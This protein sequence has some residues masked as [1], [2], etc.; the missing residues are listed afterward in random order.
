MSGS[1]FMEYKIN[2][3][4]KYF[5]PNTVLFSNENERITVAMLKD[6]LDYILGIIAIESPLVEPY[7]TA[8]TVFSAMKMIL[9]NKKSSKPSKMDM[10]TTVDVL[11]EITNLF[12]KSEWEKEQN[13]RYAF[14]CKLMIDGFG[15][16]L[17][18]S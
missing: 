9:E 4:V 7:K 5:L 6:A 17:S 2:K 1:G 14:L 12:A 11:E 16:N 8:K 13:A 18:A 15:R 3:K 10:K